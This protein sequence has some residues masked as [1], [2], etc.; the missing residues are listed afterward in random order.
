[1]TVVGDDQEFADFVTA[2]MPAVLRW[3][4]LLTGDR[5]RAEDLVQHAFAATYRHWRRIT[6]DGAEAYVRKA[7]LNAHLSWWRR[8][9]HRHERPVGEVPERP[10]SEPA[11][12][13]DE[14]DAMWAALAGLPPRQR[15]VLVLR[16]YEDLSEAEIARVLDIAP[17]TVKSQAA[18]GL[19]HLRALGP[20][21]V[22]VRKDLP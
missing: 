22:P 16:Y 6:P 9:P 15:A 8:G 21:L 10:G 7:V 12:V 17:G 3:A 5:G 14:R 11:G 1:L 4:H 18:K 20:D 2:R 13:V 19:A